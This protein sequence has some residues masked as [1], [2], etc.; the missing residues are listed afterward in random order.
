MQTAFSTEK[1][2]AR[3]CGGVVVPGARLGRRSK[4]PPRPRAAQHRPLLQSAGSS[5]AHRHSLRCPPP[6]TS[7]VRPPPRQE[8]TASTQRSQSARLPAP[9]PS[10]SRPSAARYIAARCKTH[11]QRA[12]PVSGGGTT[13]AAG[14]YR[15]AES[16]PTAAVP[17]DNPHRSCKLTRA[18]ARTELAGA[19]L[20]PAACT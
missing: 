12:T 16:W 4:Q 8:Q 6:E 3:V 1:T 17:M 14:M 19:V 5:S 10:G 11:T 15:A 2:N 18:P 13:A 7:P 9:A 20:A